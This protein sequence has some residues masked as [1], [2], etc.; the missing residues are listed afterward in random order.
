[1]TRLS[2][3]ALALS[4][5]FLAAP[6]LAQDAKAEKGKKNAAAGAFNV[7]K[8]ITLSAEQQAK[9]DELKK[10]LEPLLVEALKK[11]EG[12]LTPDQR[13]ARAT[14]GK[15]ARAAGKKGKEI[16]AAVDEAVKLSEEQKSQLAEAHRVVTDLQKKA[17]DGVMGLLTEEQKSSLKKKKAKT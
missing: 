1:M 7:P 8:T 12:I 17:R 5:A 6:A 14:A 2:L 10:Q 15:D 11:E 4:L 16:Q 9:L 3:A 13:A